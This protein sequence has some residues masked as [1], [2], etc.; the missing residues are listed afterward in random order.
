MPTPADAHNA[1]SL[2]GRTIGGRYTIKATI[3]SGGMGH[4]Y[5]ATQAPINREVAIKVLRLDLAHQEGVKE[6]F[7]RE[8]KAASLI[9]HPNAITLFDFGEDGDIL[10]LAM[11]FL[12]GETLRQRLRREPPLEVEQALDMFESM[13]GALGAAHRVGVVHRDLKP[14]NI[15]LAK[16]DAV[17]EVVKVLDFG[18]AKLLDRAADTEG[19]VTDVNLRLGTPRYMAPEQAL[20]LQPID[21]RCDVYALALLLFEMLAQRAPF[22]GEDG[23][24]VLAQRLRREAPRLSQIAPQKGFSSEMDQLLADM[25]QRDREKRPLD[26]NVILGRL[27]ELRKG[28]MVYR[29]EGDAEPPPD[30]TPP[31]TAGRSSPGAGRPTGAA[32]RVTNPRVGSEPG[33][34]AAPRSQPEAMMRLDQDD[35]D[36]DKPTVVVDP[37]AAMSGPH[38]LPLRGPP[39]PGGALDGPTALVPPGMSISGLAPPPGAAVSHSD[40]HSPMGSQYGRA[41]SIPS[42]I[43]AGS[44]GTSGDYPD[45]AARSSSQGLTPGQIGTPAAGKKRLVTIVVVVV[46]LAAPILALLIRLLTSHGDDRPD[47]SSK[48]DVEAPSRPSTPPEPKAPPETPS[49]AAA[50]PDSPAQD[51]KPAPQVKK[52]QSKP[53]PKKPVA[54][55][56]ATK[57]P[58]GKA[59]PKGPASF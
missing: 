44:S 52:V 36:V 29:Q 25:L 54:K 59:A 2:I 40:G 41:P 17:G 20:G 58:A 30:P 34:P 31:R 15:F 57:P 56:P 23:M 37:A 48:D 6:R 53:V 16:F 51:K 27:R 24:E 50:V 10:Y 46:A 21:S 7:Q 22:V 18:L 39:G 3:G 55:P 11:E 13:A 9:Q 45:A 49:T 26:A 5:R 35:Y 47:T 33:R 8:A 43:I 12:S 28:G 38:G 32:L 1:S 19:L 4:V 14:D 42:M